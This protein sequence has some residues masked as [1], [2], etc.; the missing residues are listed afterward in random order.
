MK[1]IRILSLS[2]GTLLAGSIA[3]GAI[4]PISDN[5]NA[6]GA[7]SW[8][9]GGSTWFDEGGNGVGDDADPAKDDAIQWD[10]ANTNVPTNPDPTSDGW[11]NLK[12]FGAVF[13]DIG[14]YAGETGVSISATFGDRGN[15][16]FDPVAFEIWIGDLDATLPSE[17]GNTLQVLGTDITGPSL[18]GSVTFDPFA[19]D[20]GTS[21]QVVG[22][23]TDTITG[24]S[25]TLGEAVWLRISV[26]DSDTGNLNHSQ[27][28]IGEL[29]VTAVPE[30]ATYALMA[31]LLAMG[32]ILFRR[33]RR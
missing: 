27:S 26:I 9:V 12:D 29:S 1:M 20:G 21:T 11:L 22:I 32:L 28:L 30:P 7:N 23:Q 3:H 31:G 10:G 6:G 13:R 25:G 8:D 5:F 15:K 19:S 4:V 16:L 33:R 17:D 2:I 18:A 14:T 24:L